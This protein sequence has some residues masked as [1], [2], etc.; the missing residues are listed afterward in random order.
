LIR[1][2]KL[3]LSDRVVQYVPA[4][5]GKGSG[6]GDGDRRDAVTVEHLLTHSSGLP[7][8]RPLFKEVSSYDALLER[9]VGTELESAPGTKE[10]YSDLGFILLGEVAAQAGGKPL[11]EL[12]RKLLLEP[13]GLGSTFRGPGPGTTARPEIAART[14]PTEALPSGGFLRGVVHD[15]NA[16]ASGGVTGHAGLFS[17]AEDLALFAAELLRGLR[18]ESRIF[19]RELLETFTRRRGLVAGSSRALGWDTPSEGSSAGTL[20][21]P[22][23]FGH[24]G[25]TGTSLWIDPDRDVFILLLSNRVHP[26][27][28]SLKILSVRRELA[29]IVIL[30]LEGKIREF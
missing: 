12:E 4:F 14:A 13:L 8:W 7:A 5:R 27:R 9:I 20:L 6:D 17:T 2:G 23:A 22:R 24:T 16:R 10:V 25:F 29:D 30:E 11:V 21:G 3:S 28:E 15:E 19:P 26:T 18:G 1:D